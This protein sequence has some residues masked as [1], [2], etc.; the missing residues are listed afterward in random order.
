MKQLV[1]VF[2]SL[3]SLSQ[4]LGFGIGFIDSASAQVFRCDDTSLGNDEREENR[5]ENTRRESKVVLGADCSNSN[6]YEYL[7]ESGKRDTEL[8]QQQM[9]NWEERSKRAA[10]ELYGINSPNCTHEGLRRQAREEE[11]KVLTQR[12]E[13]FRILQEVQRENN[14]REAVASARSEVRSLQESIAFWYE[15][16]DKQKRYQQLLP[17]AEEDLR[18][19]EQEL[20]DYLTQKSNR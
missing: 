20:Q 7:N 1:L 16:P 9:Q 17:P 5:E 15:H 6:F 13:A 3:V 19:A 14:L 2:A 11:D 12:K 18:R 4:F 10:C 8:K